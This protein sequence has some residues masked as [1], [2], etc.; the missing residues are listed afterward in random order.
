MFFQANTDEARNIKTLLVNYEKCSGHSVNFQKSGIFFSANVTEE[1][2]EEISQILGV[3][4][5]ITNTKYLG[6]P[7][8][9]GRST[10][11]VFQYLK[12][13]A[14]KRI[15]GWQ[16]KPMSQGGKTVLIRNVAQAIPSNNMSCFLIPTSL[17]H[18]LEQMLNNYWWRSGKG[19]NQKG[20][21]W[22]S[23]NNMSYAKSKGGL[24]FR[25]LHGFNIA[26]LGKHI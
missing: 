2:R 22:I 10:R 6:L 7:S 4:T 26:L 14:K 9:V 16:T 17:C 8:L 15:Q 21:N 19:D 23:C 24:G 18:E 20:L 11:R 12:D 3:H 5:S 25:N 1:K 13:K